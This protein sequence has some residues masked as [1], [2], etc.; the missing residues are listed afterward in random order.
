MLK[1]RG[2]RRE[3]R[4]LVPGRQPHTMPMS[5]SVETTGHRIPASP[6]EEASVRGKGGFGIGGG[7]VVRARGIVVWVRRPT[8]RVVRIK[9]DLEVPHTTNTRYTYTTREPLALAPKE[10]FF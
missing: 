8:V 1:K 4:G 3:R 6:M 7:C 2:K 9:V 5:I 10:E